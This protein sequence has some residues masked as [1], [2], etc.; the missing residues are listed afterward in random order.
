[1]LHCVSSLETGK[2]IHDKYK[3]I[4]SGFIFGWKKNP[5]DEPLKKKIASITNCCVLD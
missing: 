2:G 1:M 4:N 3:Q 5:F